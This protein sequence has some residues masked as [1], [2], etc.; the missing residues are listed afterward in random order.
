MSNDHSPVLIFA[1]CLTRDL[2]VDAE[3]KRITR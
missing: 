2:E 3:G 1:L